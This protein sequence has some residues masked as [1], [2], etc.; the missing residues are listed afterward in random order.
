MS[1][2]KLH[3]DQYTEH[4]A[5]TE[6]VELTQSLSFANKDQMIAKQQTGKVTEVETVA[7]VKDTQ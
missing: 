4:D 6:L 1:N 5:W 3:T 7:L 2:Q